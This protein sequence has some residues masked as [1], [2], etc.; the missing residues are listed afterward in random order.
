MSKELTDAEVIGK[1]FKLGMG[2]DIWYQLWYKKDNDT[3]E[4][5]TVSY[6]KDI[7]DA[8]R[9]VEIDWLGGVRK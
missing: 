8:C 7:E 4:R 9:L 5:T 1:S 6:G 3:K 2:T